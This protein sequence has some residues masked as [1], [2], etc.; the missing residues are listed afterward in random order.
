M[1][2]LDFQMTLQGMKSGIITK[3]TRDAHTR[4]MPQ[5]GGFILAEV[6]DAGM[7]YVGKSMLKNNRLSLNIL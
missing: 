3:N 1:K 5:M 7:N 2:G 4:D 6:K